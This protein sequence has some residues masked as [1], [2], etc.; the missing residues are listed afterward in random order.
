MAIKRTLQAESLRCD[1]WGGLVVIT[2][3]GLVLLLLFGLKGG[4]KKDFGGVDSVGEGGTLTR[5]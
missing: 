2:R 5:E 3:V 4:K 1:A